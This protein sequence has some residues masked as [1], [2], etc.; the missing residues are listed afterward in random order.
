MRGRWKANS[1]KLIS[2]NV[3]CVQA[4]EILE[5]YLEL[6]AVRVQLI[7]KSKEIPRDMVEAISS[8]IYAAQ[9]RVFPQHAFTIISTHGADQQL[10]SS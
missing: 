4:Y 6:I 1:I 7:A 10:T 2:I 8:I 3:L 5:L 9:V